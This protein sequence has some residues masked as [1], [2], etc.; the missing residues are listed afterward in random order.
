[1]S[2]PVFMSVVFA[3]IAFTAFTLLSA[4]RVY[5]DPSSGLIWMNF[6]IG[7]LGMALTTRQLISRKRE[8]PSDV[9]RYSNNWNYSH[10]D[11]TAVVRSGV[12]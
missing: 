2:S 11:R 7:V 1:M 9:S 5:R 3:F 6:V 4:V 8:R 10:T 12:H